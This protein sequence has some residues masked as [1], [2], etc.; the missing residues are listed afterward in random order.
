MLSTTQLIR[1]CKKSGLERWQLE[2]VLE[3]VRE[4]KFKVSENK[5]TIGRLNTEIYFLEDRIGYLETPKM[6][7]PSAL[8]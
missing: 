7:R 6:L 1:M 8:F 4:Y 5:D 2:L 3:V